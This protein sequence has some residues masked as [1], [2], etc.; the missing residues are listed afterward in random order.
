MSG[1]KICRMKIV[2]FISKCYVRIYTY[3]SI[4]KNLLGVLQL[5]P[6]VI[7]E[8]NISMGVKNINEN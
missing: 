2:G 1:R 8:K 3:I 7:L 6:K 4:N 5:R